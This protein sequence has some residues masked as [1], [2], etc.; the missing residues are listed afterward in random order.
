MSCGK[1]KLYG[2]LPLAERKWGLCR[3]K[4]LGKNQN[5]KSQ[6]LLS[7][8]KYCSSWALAPGSLQLPLLP[9]DWEVF[10]RPGLCI[11]LPPPPLPPL[12][13]PAN[14]SP[15]ARRKQGCDLSPP[16]P[17]PR[18]ARVLRRNNTSC[19]LLMK[20]WRPLTDPPINC[21]TGRRPPVGTLGRVSQLWER[22]RTQTTLSKT[23]N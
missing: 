7:S 13:Q 9:R 6:E 3:R 12:I 10:P 11:P 14:Q 2:W 4:E 1:E 15:S 20:A 18:L 22:G 21:A 5:R 19:G 17:H 8:P 23:E 16:P